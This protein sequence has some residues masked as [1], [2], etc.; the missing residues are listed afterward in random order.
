MRTGW[1]IDGEELL[2]KVVVVTRPKVD[3]PVQNLMSQARWGWTVTILITHA[4]LELVDHAFTCVHQ[5]QKWIKFRLRPSRVLSL[6][7]QDLRS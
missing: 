4:A 5:D 7:F 6:D 1:G 2:S 3:K